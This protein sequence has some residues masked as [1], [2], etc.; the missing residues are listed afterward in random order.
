[1]DQKISRLVIHAQLDNTINP[2]AMTVKY[3]AKLVQIN[4]S[5]LLARPQQEL[6]VLAN[7]ILKKDI[8][9]NTQNL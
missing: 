2:V 9:N 3:I 5:V 1:L 4:R 6:V 7:A 8:M